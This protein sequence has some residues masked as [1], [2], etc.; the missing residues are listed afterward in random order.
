MPNLFERVIQ[1]YLSNSSN[2][3]QTG[4][5]I[6]RNYTKLP[7]YNPQYQL[8]GITYKAVDKIG[9]S[10][11]VYEPMLMRGETELKEHWV[12]KLLEKP[13]PRQNKTYFLHLWAMLYEIYGEAFFYLERGEF[14]NQVKAMWLL[15]P[16]QVE[17]KIYEGELVG[18]VLHKL[19]GTQVP[20]LV[21][22]VIHDKRPNPFNEWR[23]MS[24]LEKASLYINT[25]I[26]VSSFTY[27]YIR[28]S[29]SPSGILSLP[30][31][32]PTAFQQFAQQWREGYEGADN[33]GKTA[34]IRGGEAQFTQVGATLADLDTK[35]L[36]DMTKD[37]VLMMLEVPRPLL[38]L[39]DD[40]GFGRGNLDALYYIFA[41]EK[42]NPMMNVLDNIFEKLLE[43]EKSDRQTTIT[44][45][46]PIPEDKEF[47]IN[48]Y[49]AGVGLW[50]TA[51][52]VR[53]LEGLE[54]HP[55]GNNLNIPKTPVVNASKKVVIKKKKTKAEIKKIQKQ[56][57]EEFRQKLQNNASD[58][59]T[60]FKRTISKFAESQGKQVVE[61]INATGKIFDEWLFTIKDESEVLYLELEPL[62]EELLAL[63]VEDMKDFI[64][65]EDIKV[66]PAMKKVAKADIRMIAGL[67]NEE[68]Y[69]ALEKTLTEGQAAGESLVSMKKR[70]EQVYTD[71]KG[72]RAERIARSETLRIANTAAEY[73]YQEAGYSSVEWFTNPGACEYCASVEGMTKSIGGSFFDIGQ[74]VVGTDGNKFLIDYRNIETP[75]LHPNCRCS[76]TPYE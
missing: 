27:N 48:T 8:Q 65:N 21:E 39:T 44:H 19:D 18:Y 56:E 9:L 43:Q 5:L 66:N 46:S 17:L 31:M 34:F 50:L 30:E 40:K 33:A 36:K 59:A 75:P 51:N 62:I 63:Q 4:G 32:N 11:S 64:N 35:I 42:L 72:Y 61:R 45:V 74:E 41:K 57:Q 29:A 58:Y 7:E 54:P 60:E 16:A 13:N 71:A 2:A 24:V 76:I 73:S 20:L 10:V 6:A 23:G 1:K 14:T 22:D 37:D 38:G 3:S 47:K 52:E 26:V 12:K 55:D 68:T 28:N 67:Y 15:N 70:V 25:E 69:K 49:K 53:A